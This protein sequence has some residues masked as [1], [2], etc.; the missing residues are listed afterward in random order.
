MQR[1]LAEVTDHMQQQYTAHRYLEK[2]R[3]ENEGIAL[4]EK[5]RVVSHQQS[6]DK[7]GGGEEENIPPNETLPI[8][9]LCYYRLPS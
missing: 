3:N 4:K 7:V 5:E 8:D 2:L 9:D 1:V 6:T